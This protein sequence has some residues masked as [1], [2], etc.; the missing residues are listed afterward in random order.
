MCNLLV[1][2][3]F[4]Q[5]TKRRVKLLGLNH[6]PR[7]DADLAMMKAGEEAKIEPLNDV[8]VI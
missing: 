1:S 5:E 2:Q 8:T 7:D 4:L 6:R 3:H